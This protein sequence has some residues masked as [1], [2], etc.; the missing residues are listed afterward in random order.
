M[1]RKLL[2]L[3]LAMVFCIGTVEAR[4]PKPWFSLSTYKTFGPDEDVQVHLSYQD[5]DEIDF[6]VYRVKDPVLFF[7]QLE[8]LHA[9]GPS[10][11]PPQKKGRIEALH[12]AKQATFT[13]VKGYIHSQL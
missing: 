13:K 6:R 11:R 3:A 12:A 9:F 10:S 7:E 8:E 1:R 4:E 2:A 5:L